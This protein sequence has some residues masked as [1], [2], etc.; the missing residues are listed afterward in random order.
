MLKGQK[1]IWFMSL[2]TLIV[3]ESDGVKV[4]EVTQVPETQNR[5]KVQKAKP[6]Y[7][8]RLSFVE[9]KMIFFF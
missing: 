3:R 1:K 7:Q 6:I 8:R 5:R 2:V 4:E 9:V